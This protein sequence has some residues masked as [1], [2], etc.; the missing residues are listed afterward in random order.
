[1][2]DNDNLD[3]CTKTEEYQ[4]CHQSCMQKNQVEVEADDV[5]AEYEGRA[6]DG[7]QTCNVFFPGEL[8][9]CMG[10]GGDCVRETC[11][12]GNVTKCLGSQS[13][14]DCHL[15]CMGGGDEIEEV[16][17]EM[18]VCAKYEQMGEAAIAGC[19]KCAN[20]YSERVEECMACGGVCNRNVCDTSQLEAALTNVGNSPEQI[21]M[22]VAHMMAECSKTDE[23][24]ACH[25]SCME[26]NHSNTSNTSI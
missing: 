11:E 7:C 22:A 4:G 16:E 23:Y 18:M 17:E 8:E 15:H 6:L 25:Q 13:F 10:C 9:K 21:K 1:V 26:T 12:G 19:A 5:C 14:R 2:C 24:R 3:N 20:H